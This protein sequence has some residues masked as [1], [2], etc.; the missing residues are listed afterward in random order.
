MISWGIKFFWGSMGHRDHKK[1]F[2][3]N[4]G[5]DFWRFRDGTI[6]VE[7]DVEG[8]VFLARVTIYVLNASILGN[9]TWCVSLSESQWDHSIRST[10]S[11]YYT[12]GCAQSYSKQIYPRFNFLCFLG[13]IVAAVHINRISK[14]APP[15]PRLLE[16]LLLNSKDRQPTWPRGSSSSTQCRFAGTSS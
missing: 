9:I 2:L 1:K 10:T 5:I 12:D 6:K 8:F 11:S 4:F 7:R 13:K 16:Q 3:V 15:A 14:I